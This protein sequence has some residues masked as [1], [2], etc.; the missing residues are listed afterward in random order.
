MSRRAIFINEY[1]KANPDQRARIIFLNYTS[2][3]DIIEGYEQKI[4]IRIMD[5]LNRARRDEIGDLGV[6]IQGSGMHSSPTERIGIAE[7]TIEAAIRKN[8]LP[9][10][11]LVDME[12]AEEHIRVTN[13]LYMMRRDFKSVE[14]SI[15]M[16]G[17]RDASILKEALKGVPMIEIGDRVNMSEHY[18]R[19]M[20]SQMKADIKEQL[21]DEYKNMKWEA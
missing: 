19:N 11:M 13:I 18:V 20:V 14:A 5:E 15:K 6:R 4:I 16:Y 7:V 1:G 21:A 3:P 12:T 17:G 10:D 9:E 2:F 8:K